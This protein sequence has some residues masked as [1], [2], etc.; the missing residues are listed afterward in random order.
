MSSHSPSLIEN[1]YEAAL[2]PAQWSSVLSEIRDHLGANAYSL[3]TLANEEGQKPEL[4][5]SN[6]DPEWSRAYR[7]HWWQ[8]DQ[9]VEGAV[10]RGLMA[11]AQTVSGNMLV[12]PEAFAKGTWF[13]EALK[14][15]DLGDL[16]ST[17]LWSHQSDTQKVILSFYRSPRADLFG[18]REVEHLEQLSSHL[19]RALKLTMTSVR[20]SEEFQKQ[21]SILDGL[22]HPVLILD[23]QRKILSVNA[24]AERLIGNPA[25][26]ALNIRGNRLVEIGERSTPSLEQAIQEATDLMG[27]PIPMAFVMT[28]SEGAT[29]SGSVRVM[30][31][32]QPPTVNFRL[33]GQNRFMVQ[34]EWTETPAP[35]S[36]I[37]FGD[38]FGLSPAE[39]R[40]FNLMMGEH[41]PQAIADQLG[42]SLPT[43][44]THLQRIRQKTGTRRYGDL[45]R[46]A[47]STAHSH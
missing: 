36:L 4:L 38:L 19:R 46:L 43:V 11:P 10:G 3:F 30:K 13:N 15:Q 23:D 35:E 25:C 2:D 5:T 32:K 20:Q 33:E 42:I 28:T 8:H 39:L 18:N 22:I 16:L 29:I 6:I 21:T 37:L 40:V 9:W 12:N 14:P 45:I 31:L 34:L 47:L 17:T 1:I 26:P 44:R 24:A 41:P 7:E 27:H